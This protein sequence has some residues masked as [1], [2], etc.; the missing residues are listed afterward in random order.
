MTVY[1]SDIPG[2]GRK[3]ELELAGGGRAVVL[4]HHDGRRELFHRPSEDEDS[5]KLLDLSGGEAGQLAAMLQAT[6]IV[7][8]S[9]FVAWLGSAKAAEKIYNAQ[10][11]GKGAATCTTPALAD[12]RIYIRTSSGVVCHDLRQNRKDN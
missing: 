5:E 4:V 9:G 6:D 11:R 2:V 1:E 10:V 8:A 12:G 7:D 3:F